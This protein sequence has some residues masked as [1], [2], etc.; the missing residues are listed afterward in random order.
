MIESESI[1]HFEYAFKIILKEK[2]MKKKENERK[3]MRTSDICSGRPELWSTK[4]SVGDASS[5][6]FHLLAISF[7]FMVHPYF[8]SLKCDGSDGGVE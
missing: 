1:F 2:R 5:Y 3:G 8:I 4:V 7:P 6:L